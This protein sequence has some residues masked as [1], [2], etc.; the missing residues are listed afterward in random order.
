MA[1]LEHEVRT[2]Q[3]AMTGLQR[4]LFSLDEYYSFGRVRAFAGKRVELIE[5]EIIEMLPIGPGHMYVTDPLAWLLQRI[6][7]DDYTV[8]TQGPISLVDS[9]KPSEPQPD[10]VVAVGCRKTYVARHPTALDIKLIVEVAET[11]LAD[12]RGIKAALYAAYQIP[13]YWIVNLVDRQL[14]VY[15]NPANGTY[16]ELTNV[17]PDQSITPLYS[18]SE[19]AV[20]PAD[21]LP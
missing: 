14:E 15:R 11:S 16:S 9:S 20:V 21:F 4:Y 17:L 5:G 7:G 19:T 2:A 18:P 6:F 1:I 3:A 12:D 10:I 13:E 8:R